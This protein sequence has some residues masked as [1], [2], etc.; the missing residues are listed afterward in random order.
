[1]K[2]KPKADSQANAETLKTEKLKSDFSI[3][4]K[5]ILTF[6]FPNFSFPL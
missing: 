1:M 5:A 6:S 3:S 2:P 4:G